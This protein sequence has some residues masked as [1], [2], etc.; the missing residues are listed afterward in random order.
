MNFGLCGL[1]SLSWWVGL[2]PNS[3]PLSSFDAQLGWLYLEKE[4]T[5]WNLKRWDAWFRFYYPVRGTRDHWYLPTTQVMTHF[6]LG[7]VWLEKPNLNF[8]QNQKIKWKI[9]LLYLVSFFAVFKIA[10]LQRGFFPAQKS[11]K[12]TLCAGKKETC[13][14]WENEH[15]QLI[16]SETNKPLLKSLASGYFPVISKCN[17]HTYIWCAHKWVPTYI[18][19]R[20]T[21]IYK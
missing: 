3:T 19:L 7:H 12:Q 2:A 1:G 11:A 17:K 20:Y 6:Y 4:S 8:W 15:F 9:N 13:P 16:F 18:F 14:F 5:T 10:G 21:Y